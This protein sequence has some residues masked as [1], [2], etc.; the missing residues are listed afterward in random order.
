[1]KKILFL[2]FLF[3]LTIF[4]LYKEYNLAENKEILPKNNFSQTIWETKILPEV[5]AFP[6]FLKYFDLLPEAHKKEFGYIFLTSWNMDIRG[7]NL[8]PEDYFKGIYYFEN[9]ELKSFDF[10]DKEKLAKLYKNA[11][12]YVNIIPQRKVDR[13][14]VWFTTKNYAFDRKRA[15]IYISEDS[16]SSILFIH[17]YGHVMDYA[18]GFTD[19]FTPKYPYYDKE[20]AI[21]EYGKFHI[22]EDFAEAY[23]Y[24]IL[25]NVTFHKKMIDNQ[26]ITDK[27]NY[28]KTFAFDNYEYN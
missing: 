23:R 3:F 26:E 28:L 10:S 15:D 16:A 27:Y 7:A 22:G 18:F 2:I 1:M 4:I 12:E 5:S 20:N 11:S 21:T 24:Y 6:E 19:T 25:H 9:K 17:E 13:F 14:S 8:K